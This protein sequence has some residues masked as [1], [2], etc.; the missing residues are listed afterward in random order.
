MRKYKAPGTY[1]NFVPTKQAPVTTFNQ[2][3]IL[4]I[5]GT[6]QQTFERK[7]VLIERSSTSVVDKLPDKNIVSIETISTKPI[8]QRQDPTNK[9][10]NDYKCNTENSTIVWG[11]LKGPSFDPTVVLKAEGEKNRFD[12]N[13]E[14]TVVDKSLIATES[15]KFE[16]TNVGVSGQGTFRV[17]RMSNGDIIGEYVASLEQTLDIIP[18]LRIKVISTIFYD[19]NQNVM[20]KIGDYVLLKTECAKCHIDPTFKTTLTANTTTNALKIK[21]GGSK[22]S[23]IGVVS[24]NKEENKMTSISNM[25]SA[26]GDIP[27]VKMQLLLYKNGILVN[28]KDAFNKLEVLLKGRINGSEVN[29]TIVLYEDERIGTASDM[30]GN[31]NSYDLSALIESTGLAQADNFEI[32]YSYLVK[33]ELMLDGSNIVLYLDFIKQPPVSSDAKKA[34]RTA[35]EVTG[36]SSIAVINNAIFIRNNVVPHDVAS[37]NEILKSIIRNARITSK[38]DIRNGLYKV[39]IKNVANN[40]ISIFNM[41]TKEL[42]GTWSTSSVNNFRNAIP[43]FSFELYSF[44]D[45]EGLIE[46]CGSGDINDLS[47][48][49]V[50]FEMIEGII[51]PEVP[52]SGTEYYVTYRYSKSEEDYEPKIFSNYNEIVKEYGQYLMTE[53]GMIIN[54]ISLAA[55]IAMLNGASP[56]A[57]VQAKSET[58][59]EYK[60]AI[61]KLGTKIGNTDN[62]NAV[63]ALTDSTAVN[64]YLVEHV[65]KYS[66]PDYGM[67][68]MTYLSSPANQPIDKEPSIGNPM[69]GAIQ[70]AK[71][72]NDERCVY[73]VPGA[74]IK[75]VLNNIT[76]FSNLKVLPGYY[77]TTAVAALSLRND[78]AEPLTNKQIYGFDSLVNYYNE[79]ELNLLSSSGCLA[80][81]Q[82]SNG[83]KVRHGVTTHGAIETLADIQSNEIT[84][85]QIKD[86]VIN[87]CKTSIGDKYV[88]GKLKPS[89]V[90]DVEFTI[91]ML[92]NKY[93]ADGIIINY[94][95]LVV[96]RDLEDPR[97][98]NVRFLIEAVYPLNYID[99]TFGF[100]TTIS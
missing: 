39:K 24:G 83:L 36:N 58:V 86:Y 41:T 57:L 40:E 78:P 65:N 27:N 73:V 48:S 32:K 61:D 54:G 26:V 45:V 10:F 34:K 56:I 49:G 63:V 55:E 94:E 30:V 64:Q 80:V 31:Q 33:D 88:G 72:I 37:S 68:R 87:G 47:G 100:S 44:R 84:L 96:V 46:M 51:N 53:S 13:I 19:E 5:V 18:G 17:S 85:V 99:I 98:L 90:A 11:Q 89:I 62:V 81:K 76:G 28:C 91:K 21:D 59:E 35:Y 70:T 92:L 52:Q 2:Q 1:A 74:V 4:A 60:K 22:F 3:R 79:P 67:Y 82:D 43:G 66:S 6:G 29:K 12:E 14:F 25:V 69:L 75:N 42:I 95:D 15:Y 71:S 38:S 50:V 16:I 20:S 77:L 8:T 9:L 97:Q 7:N 23:P 93:I